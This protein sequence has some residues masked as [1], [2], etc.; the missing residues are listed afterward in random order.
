MGMM[1]TMQLTL[2][3]SIDELTRCHA[4]IAFRCKYQQQINSKSS[5]IILCLVQDLYVTLL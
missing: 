5:V 4:E 3:K 1:R 2:I